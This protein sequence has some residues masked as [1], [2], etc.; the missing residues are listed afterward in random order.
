MIA[1][2]RPLPRNV[3]TIYRAKLLETN[4]ERDTGEMRDDIALSHFLQSSRPLR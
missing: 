3:H 4:H 1:S 2:L